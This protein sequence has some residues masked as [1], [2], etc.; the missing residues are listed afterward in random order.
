MPAEAAT[1]TIA[2]IHAIFAARLRTV[3]MNTFPAGMARLV[4]RFGSDNSFYFSTVLR[5][6]LMMVAICRYM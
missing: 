3:G 5:G 2:S 1:S 6:C 4:P